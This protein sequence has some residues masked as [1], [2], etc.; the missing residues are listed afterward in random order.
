MVVAGPLCL[1]AAA[2]EA[3]GSKS[4]PA[5]AIELE[6]DTLDQLEEALEAGVTALLLD[7]KAPPDLR[8]AVEMTGGRA[9]LEA[10][11]RVTSDT[12]RAIAETGVDYISSGWI[13]HSAPALDFGLDFVSG[14]SSILSRD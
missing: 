13:T 5:T 2:I 11:G 7:N 4:G 6:V 9:V 14:T 8:R 12:V 1:L 3:A 10:S